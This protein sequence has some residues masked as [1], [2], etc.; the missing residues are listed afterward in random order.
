M[1]D[2]QITHTYIGREFMWDRVSDA[3]PAMLRQ[4][5]AAMAWVIK[6]PARYPDADFAKAEQIVR[7]IDE[8]FNLYGD[9]LE[10]FA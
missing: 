2:T 10:Q 5:R 9:L 4:N 8:F 6:N 1:I 3:D 7:S